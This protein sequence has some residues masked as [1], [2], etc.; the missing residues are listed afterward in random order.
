MLPAIAMDAAGGR[1]AVT[2]VATR[3][4]DAPRIAAGVVAQGST[5]DGR[6]HPVY[7]LRLG[8]RSTF[9][10]NISSNFG[11]SVNIYRRC[12]AAT[13]TVAHSSVFGVGPDQRITWDLAAG[14]YYVVIVDADV[15]PHR[16]TYSVHTDVEPDY[17]AFF[18]R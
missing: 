9:T 13:S 8:D 14:E 6:Q 17:L 18:R 10:L 5:A 4:T 16:G 11:G 12:P 15:H 3:C 2:R 7:Q 1:L